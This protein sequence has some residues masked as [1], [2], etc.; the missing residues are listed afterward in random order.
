LQ[1]GVKN[2]ARQLRGT[3]HDLDLLYYEFALHEMVPFRPAGYAEF[4][5][6]RVFPNTKEKTTEHG[7][8][9][10]KES[11]VFHYRYFKS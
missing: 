8:Q 10:Q 6:L 1:T 7:E 2:P 4:C 3:N 5:K 9:R 11:R